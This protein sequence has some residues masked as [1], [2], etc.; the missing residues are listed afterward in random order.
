[1]RRTLHGLMHDGRDQILLMSFP[2]GLEFGTE[3]DNLKRRWRRV[4]KSQCNALRISINMWIDWEGA[5]CL[6]IFT[7]LVSKRVVRDV[8]MIQFFWS[9]T[10]RGFCNAIL[11]RLFLL[12][13][14]VSVHVGY[15]A[16][17]MRMLLRCS[18]E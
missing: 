7:L 5:K 14:S 8:N 2:K 6:I 1:M 18:R 9:T 17:G 13:R 3:E 11:L 15:F 4:L 16:D 12:L 10:I